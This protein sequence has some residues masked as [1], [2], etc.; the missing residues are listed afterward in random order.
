MSDH[1]VVQASDL[2]RQFSQL[3]H[4]FRLI[5]MHVSPMDD[6]ETN[7]SCFIRMREILSR[8]DD[9]I[10]YYHTVIL[11]Q[12]VEASQN[13]IDNFICIDCEMANEMASEI[14][15]PPVTR[16]RDWVDGRPHLR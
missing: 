3:L 2:R 7:Y 12:D 8:M 15:I 11:A 9:I 13:V 14:N 16:R 6:F 10:Q 1:I 4:G 5:H